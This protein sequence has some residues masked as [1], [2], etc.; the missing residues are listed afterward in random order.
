MQ[1]DY[2]KEF[3]KKNVK[4]G[5]SVSITVS[6]TISACRS[7][8]MQTDSDTHLQSWRSCYDLCTDQLLEHKTLDP[9][10]TPKYS[11]VV[12]N[13]ISLQIPELITISGSHPPFYL[14]LYIL[15]SC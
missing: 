9:I 4:M 5:R 1:I 2:G 6:Y 3:T 13:R 8:N 14:Q 10:P 11:L 15:L 12:L 7:R